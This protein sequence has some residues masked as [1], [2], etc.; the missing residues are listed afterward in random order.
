VVNS[1]FPNPLSSL[2]HEPNVKHKVEKLIAQY[3][4]KDCGCHNFTFLIYKLPDE[5]GNSGNE[6][7]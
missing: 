3:L 2:A 1:S 7:D 6:A 4:N 5:E